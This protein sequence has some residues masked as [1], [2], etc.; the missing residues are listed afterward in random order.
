VQDHGPDGQ[1]SI[2]AAIDGSRTQDPL[3]FSPNERVWLDLD[4]PSPIRTRYFKLQLRRG[5]YSALQTKN[6]T[7]ITLLLRQRPGAPIDREDR[8]PVPPPLPRHQPPRYD[9]VDE[10][11][12]AK[13]PFKTPVY[14]KSKPKAIKDGYE[15]AV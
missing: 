2:L 7:T 15:P 9:A 14:P 13:R 11:P 6:S 8:F 10:T 12:P 3:T 1:C 4:N 5:D